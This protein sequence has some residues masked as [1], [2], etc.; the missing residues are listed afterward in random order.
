M[1]RKR[2]EFIGAFAPYGYEK[3]PL[4]HHHLVVDEE[5]AC[6]VRMVFHWFVCDEISQIKIAQRLNDLGILNP[7]A[8]KQSKGHKY[9][10]S[11]REFGSSYW[12]PSVIKRI[13]ENPMYIGNMVQG[14]QRVKSFKCQVVEVMSKEDWIIVENTHKAVVDR[15]TFYKVQSLLARD[16]RTAP[17][18]LMLYTFSGF[19]RCADCKRAMHRKSDGKYTYYI[20]RTYTEL[21]KQACT[22]HSIREEKLKDAVFAI[23]K[24]HIRAIPDTTEIISAIQSPSAKTTNNSA[25]VLLK[26]RQRKLRRIQSYQK[27][28]Y[29]DW[30]N[31]GISEEEYQHFK[32]QYAD[33]MEQTEFGIKQLKT[34]RQSCEDIQEKECRQLDFFKQHLELDEINR[35]ILSELIDVIYIEEGGDLTVRF[36]FSDPFIQ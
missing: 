23:L 21:S 12:H 8:Y 22:R 25:E 4:D 9:Q 7:T 34:E 32:Q 31:G 36:K 3:N 17:G 28:L 30:K 14:R 1:K 5:A 13:L 24:L 16:T 20:C 35:D 10:N 29:E 6:V 18:K 11:C 19:L 2:G 26:S 33:E 15:A 27:S